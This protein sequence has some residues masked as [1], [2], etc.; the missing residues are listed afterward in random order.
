MKLEEIKIGSRIEGLVPEE[1]AT[2]VH[3]IPSGEGALTVIYNTPSIRIDQQVVY[4]EMAERLQIAEGEK[5][6]AFDAPAKKFKLGLE[7]LRLSLGSGVDPLIAVYSSNIEPLPHQIS[8]VY[9]K[10]LP[11]RPLRYV[12]ADDPGA[13][14]TVMAGLLIK[15]LILRGDA[16]RI[17]VVA[18]GS[19]TE[20]WQDELNEKFD[21]PFDL[22]VPGMLANSRTGNPFNEYPML[23]ARLDQLSRG[24]SHNEQIQ[25]ALDTAEEWDLVIIDEAHKCSASRTGQDVHYTARYRLA[26]KLGAKSRHF[27]MMTA[28][29]H[30]GKEGDF[31]LWL[32]LLD[33]DR[34]Y[35]EARDDTRMDVSDVMRRLVKEKLLK[36]DGTRL[37]P[38]RYAHT[39]NYE[40]SDEEMA[41]Y[42]HVSDYVR[43]EMNRAEALDDVRR[44]GR[45]GFAL[46][47]LQRRLAS[48]PEAI[49]QS[50]KRRRE[51]LERQLEN[52]DYCS[53]PLGNRDIDDIEDDLTAEEYEKLVE[54]LNG[55][56]ASRTPGELRREIDVLKTLQTEAEELVNS[57]KDS[58]WRE[59]QGLFTRIEGDE[60]YREA[61]GKMRKLI[62]FTEHR[63]TLEYLRQ[64]IRNNIFGLEN[65]DAVRV[66]HGGIG[67]DTRRK[68]QEEFC[69]DPDVRVL[70]ASDAAGEGVNLQRANLMINYDL[71]WNPNRIE[72]RFGRIHRIGQTLPC[73]LWN[74]VANQTREGRV[75]ETLFVKLENQRKALGGRGLR[76]SRRCLYRGS[77]AGTADEGDSRR[78][79]RR[80]LGAREDR[81]GNVDR[82]SQGTDAPQGTYP[83]GHDPR[84]GL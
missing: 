42:E 30:N 29:P 15:E 49:Y 77:A 13:G 5:G 21:L 18:P 40:L 79:H 36:F 3:T 64:K 4:R 46:T 75:F 24:L 51:R 71:P 58:K 34:F 1:I 27:L 56:T 60:E 68:T 35:G 6:Y 7:A 25:A 20:Q 48:S 82:E 38:P 53:N 50:L 10:M 67:R 80:P 17:L 23:I 84:D 26:E 19:L 72:Q 45:V 69:N 43:K 54:E 39:V 59:L 70:I 11:R 52:G 28:T 83:R 16:R 37:F 14:K 76:C 8:A 61:P 31:R 55:M 62:I 47:I 73:H 78:R 2:V 57:G 33:S 63:D 9:D 65:A 32:A 22:F 66:I 44:R 74:L 12:L 81:S 41:L